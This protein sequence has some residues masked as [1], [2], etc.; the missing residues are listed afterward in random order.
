MDVLLATRRIDV[1]WQSVS[2]AVRAG[3]LNSA[4]A[5]SLRRSV[6]LTPLATSPSTD[7]SP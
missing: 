1:A 2:D 4:E 5:S 6:S 3:L 7:G